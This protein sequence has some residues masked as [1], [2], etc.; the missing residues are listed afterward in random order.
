MRNKLALL[1]C[2]LSAGCVTQAA[3]YGSVP[4]ERATECVAHCEELD[5]KLS[6]IVIIRSSAGCVCEPKGSAARTA[7]SVGAAAG[8]AIIADEEAQQQQQ[9]AGAAGYR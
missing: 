3:T 8:G 4:K 1:L 5:M 2:L 6:A 7:S 9:Q